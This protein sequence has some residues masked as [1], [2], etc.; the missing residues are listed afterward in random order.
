MMFWKSH[1]VGTLKTQSLVSNKGFKPWVAS[2]AP[3]PPPPLVWIGLRKDYSKIFW[4]VLCIA[5]SYPYSDW[6]FLAV[7]GLGGG[8]GGGV[9]QTPPPP[10]R[11]LKTI[12]DIDMKRTPLI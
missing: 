1:E 5:W 7:P 8:G 4:L 10:L 12:K 6:A 11:F 2:N 3:P 9:R